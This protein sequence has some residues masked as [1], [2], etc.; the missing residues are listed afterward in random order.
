M[1]INNTTGKFRYAQIVN[2][3]LSLYLFKEHVTDLKFSVFILKNS[4]LA[5]C[6]KI[7][8]ECVSN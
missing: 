2:T 8:L 7:T 5:D 1:Q 4:I 6:T 3:Q